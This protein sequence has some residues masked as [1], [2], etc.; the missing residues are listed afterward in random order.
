MYKRQLEYVYPKLAEI[1]GFRWK[2]PLAVPSLF[3]RPW[4][5]RRVVEV[6]ELH[7]HQD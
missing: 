5:R 2:R 1:R 4:F 7:A 3:T 6:P